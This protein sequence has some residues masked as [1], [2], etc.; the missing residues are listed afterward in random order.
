MEWPVSVLA[1]DFGFKLAVCL[2]L[3]INYSQNRAGSEFFLAL[4]WLFYTVNSCCELL[5]FTYSSN[6]PSYII[7]TLFFVKYFSWTAMSLAFL[8][9]VL[10]FKKIEDDFKIIL[11]MLLVVSSSFA[12]AFIAGEKFWAVLPCLIIGGFSSMICAV[13]FRELRLRISLVGNQFIFYGFLLTGLRSFNQLFLETRGLFVFWDFFLSLAVTVIFAAGLIEIS[14][15]EMKIFISSRGKDAEDLSALYKIGSMNFCDTEVQNIFSEILEKTAGALKLESGVLYLLDEE[16][17]FLVP[18]TSLNIPVIL[19]EKMLQ[20][21]EMGQGLIGEAVAAGEVKIIGDIFKSSA[22]WPHMKKASSKTFIVLPLKNKNYI[23]GALVFVTCLP[24][25]FARDEIGLFESAADKISAV[26]ENAKKCI[27]VKKTS[28][29][30]GTLYNVN[31]SVKH[32]LS[33]ENL[34]DEIL[35]KVVSSLSA[36][37]G[38]IYIVNHKEDNFVLRAK[39]GLSDE[40]SEAVRSLSLDSGTLTAQAAKTRKAVC[41]EDISVYPTPMQKAVQ[42]EKLCGYCGVPIISAAGKIIGVLIVT[43][44]EVRKFKEEE[45]Q[46]L[47]CI[48]HGIATAVENAKLYEDLQ[49]VYLR[50]VTALAEVVDAKDHYTYS[51]SKYVTAFAVKIANEMKLSDKEVEILRKACQLHDIGKISISD[52]ILT[53]KRKLT[54]KEWDEVKKHPQRGAAILEPLTFLKEPKGGVI[55]LIKQHHEKY[56]GKGYPQGLKGEGIELGARIMAVADAYHA[57]ISNRP[58][59]RSLSQNKAVQ[60]LKKYANSQ[61]DPAVVDAFLKILTKEKKYAG[62]KMQ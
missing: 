20:F 33:M 10:L 43:T 21:I 58:Y 11:L 27:S 59:R 31:L 5:F 23:L 36:E 8:K 44:R 37:A 38:A 56:D 30:L 47:I 7:T 26:L 52:Y 32:Y 35:R 42:K 24:Q 2:I 49:D 29:E 1:V 57:M 48:A 55:E 60:E 45:V 46:L 9:A 50:S 12:G 3:F 15:Y 14:R 18:K 54:R 41:V 28:R 53:K 62:A 16:N 6:P 61:F 51:H 34:L 13:Y 22:N 25:V 40:F 17:K 19:R 4:G 39:I